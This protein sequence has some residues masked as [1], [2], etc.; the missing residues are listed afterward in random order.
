V[1]AITDLV[2]A[3]DLVRRFV[4]EADEALDRLSRLR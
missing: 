4:A 1:G 3:G 2:P